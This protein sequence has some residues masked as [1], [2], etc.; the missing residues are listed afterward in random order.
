M[1]AVFETRWAKI[2]ETPEHYRTVK[3]KSSVDACEF[4]DRF[5]RPYFADKR[6]QEEFL[7]ITLDTKLCPIRI[8]R[9]T[10]GTLDASLVHPREVFR[11]AIADCASAV[12]LAHN[13]PSGDS[14]PSREDIEVT[15]RLIDAGKILGIRVL[16]HLVIGDL[17]VSLADKGHL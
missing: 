5:L 12:I 6:D 16:D 10:R 3:F 11:P 9:V 17:V 4:G 14:T 7:V 13:H 8:V 15:K 2:G 1:N